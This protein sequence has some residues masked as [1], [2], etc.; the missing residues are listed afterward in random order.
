MPRLSRFADAIRPPVF[1]ELERAIAERRESGG[2]LVPLHIGDTYLAPPLVARFEKQLDARDDQLYAYGAT[3]GLSELRE[4]LARW[5]RRKGRAFEEMTADANVQVGVGATHALSC[6]ARVVIEPEDEVLLASPYWPLAHGILASAGARI[7]EVPLTSRLYADPTLDAGEVFRAHITPKTRA[8]YFITPNNP[9][10]KVLTARDVASIARVAI[11]HDLW[12]FA[13]EVY[14]DYTFGSEHVSIA[15]MDGMS[16]RTI[17][18]FSFSKSHALAGARIGW[19]L[20]PREVVA[21][22]RKV[23]THSVFNVPVVMQRAALAALSD[24]AWIE[25]ARTTYQ[26]ARD[27]AFD[28]LRG[29]NIETSLADGGVYLFLD[30]AKILDGRPLSELLARAVAQGVILAP[31]QAFGADFPTHARLCFTAV[32]LDRVTEGISRLRAAVS[33]MG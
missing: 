6:A 14:A 18:A 1:S 32:Q 11:E 33:Q 29:S 24:E 13:D 26:L 16:D 3:F 9:D 19:A 28:A 31:G 21:A 20:G 12:V 25:S 30:F 17:T 2:D 10:G 8:L 15:T 7:V 27:T 23:S 4:A 5:A 22:M